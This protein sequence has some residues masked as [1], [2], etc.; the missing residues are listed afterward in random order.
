MFRPLKALAAAALTSLLAINAAHALTVYSS[1]DEE[2][3]RKLLDAEKLP[4]TFFV[5]GWVAEHH[6][7]R[8]KEIRDRG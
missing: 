2:N 6:T 4:A 5:P 3:A 1:V 8:C 7:D